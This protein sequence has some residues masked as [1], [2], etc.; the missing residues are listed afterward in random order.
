MNTLLQEIELRRLTSQ[1]SHPELLDEHLSGGSR[2]VYCGFDPTAPSLHIGNLVPLL[3]LR[4]FQ[5]QGHRPIALVGGATGLIGDPSGRDV[6]RNLN[7][8]DTVG[9][10]VLRIKEQVS[11]FLDLDGEF[12]ATV[13]NNLDWTKD[14]TAIGFLRDIGKHFAVNAMIQRDSVK[15][16]LDREGEGISYTEFSYM[17]LQAMDFLKLY[18]QYDC[19]IQVG[20]NDQ[21]GNMVSGADL[22]RRNHQQQAYVMTVPLVTRS[23]GKKFGKT[24]G[25]AVWLD[26]E[27]TSPYAFYQFWMNLPDEDL[28]LF[29]NLFT[30]LG[31]DEIEDVVMQSQENPA[32]RIGQKIL[33]QNL[34]KL[35]HGT[36]GLDAA[37][38]ITAALFGASL[39]TLVES[40]FEQLGQDGIERSEICEGTN[41]AAALS[42]SGL[43][44]S[45]GKARQMVA[46]GAILVNDVKIE[47]ANLQLD[48]TNA[49]YGRYHL[50]R[51]GRKTWHLLELV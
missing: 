6:E 39:H 40:D 48:R 29:L 13:V 46:S 1:V 8:L 27:L 49:L 50:M 44:P 21:W 23:D 41:V 10:W 51:R 9:E 14:L 24:S 11:R 47:D 12:G 22:I 33:A 38:R 3:L 34:T 36:G 32:K 30:F 18:E 28:Q 19:T 45:R 7:D 31:I 43:A 42:E 26:V 35:V 4:R 5:M 25:G 16:R 2:T 17:I 37:E 20:G 15:A